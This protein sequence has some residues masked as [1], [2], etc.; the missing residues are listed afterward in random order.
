M[1]YLWTKWYN[2][3]SLASSYMA[4]LHGI[5][6]YPGNKVCCRLILLKPSDIHV[7]L[8]YCSFFL[9]LKF[10]M[11]LNWEE[12][13]SSQYFSFWEYCALF[14]HSFC[15][16]WYGLGKLIYTKCFIMKI[17]YVVHMFLETMKTLIETKRLL[18]RPH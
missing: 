9:C 4:S 5:W 1:K 12:L 6:E 17:I 3:W 11:T 18:L 15:F 14:S 7:D 8:L 13:A 2:I 10:S 16:L